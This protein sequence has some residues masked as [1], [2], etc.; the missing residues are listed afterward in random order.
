[1]KHHVYPAAIAVLLLGLFAAACSKDDDNG[2]PTATP[3]ELRLVAHAWNVT[4]ATV[5]ND[6]ISDSSIYS[7][8]MDDDSLSFGTDRKLQFSDG[9]EVCDSTLLPYGEGSWSFNTTEDTLWVKRGD[10]TLSWKVDNLTDSTLQISFNDIWKEDTVVKQ[11]KFT[12]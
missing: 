8:C 11:V 7:D 3:N 4:A 2:G 6:N 5:D 12:K 9:S 10:S 1:M